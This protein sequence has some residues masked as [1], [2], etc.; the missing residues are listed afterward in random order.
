MVCYE[1]VRLRALQELDVRLPVDGFTE[2]EIRDELKVDTHEELHE[3]VDRMSPEEFKRFVD[4]LL[5]KLAQ[6]AKESKAVPYIQ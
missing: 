6:R 2:E 3:K 4:Y 1:T 5:W